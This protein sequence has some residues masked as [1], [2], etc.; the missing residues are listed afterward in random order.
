MFLLALL[1]AVFFC[2]FPYEQGDE[3][4]GAVTYIYG[5]G[6]PLLNTALVSLYFFVSEFVH[7]SA[8]ARA[9]QLQWRTK[10]TCFATCVLEF[11]VQFM[12]DSLRLSGRDWSWTV[13]CRVY[14]GV[15]APLALEHVTRPTPDRRK[16]PPAP[17][18][19]GAL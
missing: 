13:V 5:V 7:H 12:S 16:E 8:R 10:A 1:R 17:L 19:H 2:A 9:N 4:S 6:F 3:V 11:G 18:P 14:L 15:C